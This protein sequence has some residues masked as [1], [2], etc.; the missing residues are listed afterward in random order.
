LENPIVEYWQKNLLL[1]EVVSAV[2]D[3]PEGEAPWDYVFDFT[4]ELRSE[5]GDEVIAI[6]LT[7]SFQLYRTLTQFFLPSFLSFF[8]FSFGSCGLFYEWHRF[9]LSA[10]L[11]YINVL[12]FSTMTVSHQTFGKTH[13]GSGYRSSKTKAKGLRPT[14][15]RLLYLSREWRSR[16]K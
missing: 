15:C 5:W 1:P 12:P 10:I 6:S 14:Q 8:L 4:G 2:F 9:L 7:R 16:R 3:P 13:Q 11:A